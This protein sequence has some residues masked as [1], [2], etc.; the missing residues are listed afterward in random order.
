MINNNMLMCITRDNPVG[1]SG[2]ELILL[3]DED[4]DGFEVEGGDEQ[5]QVKHQGNDTRKRHGRKPKSLS[6]SPSIAKKVEEE[7]V[8]FA[9]YD[10]YMI[11]P[12][13]TV[14]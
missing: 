8:F 3:Q 11:T 2:G 13:P 12:V 1:T 6:S 7:D 10:G 4:E 5:E 9:C 14:E